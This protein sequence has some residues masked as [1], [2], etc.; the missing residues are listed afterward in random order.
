MRTR[1]FE[2][3]RPGRTQAA[4][5]WQSAQAAPTGLKR[6]PEA[7]G[8]ASGVWTTSQVRALIEEQCAVRYHEAHVWR[9][10]RKLGWSCQRPSGRALE[11]DEPAI[12]H[13][14]KV[15]WPRLKKKP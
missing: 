9:I 2:E 7:W 12:L 4:P 10:L 14:K 15:E 6:G 3:S 11:R 8:Y 1:G 5:Q 13:W